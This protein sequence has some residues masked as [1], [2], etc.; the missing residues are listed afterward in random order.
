MRFSSSESSLKGLTVID[1]D[2]LQIEIKHRTR[3]I[4]IDVVRHVYAILS[5]NTM[6]TQDCHVQ[7]T[8]IPA[9]CSEYQKFEFVIYEK[10]GTDTFTSNIEPLS[11]EFRK[12]L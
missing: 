12:N 7:G 3:R 9:Y 1:P 8:Y 10:I 5:A 4:L 11:F 2:T 6:E